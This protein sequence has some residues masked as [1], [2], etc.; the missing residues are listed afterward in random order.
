M[1]RP[2]GSGRAARPPATATRDPRR[3]PLLRPART[4]AFPLGA[5]PGAAESSLRSGPTA[6]PRPPIQTRP[7]DPPTSGLA[8][9]PPGLRGCRGSRQRAARVPAH[10]AAPAPPSRGARE[11]QHRIGLR[12]RVQGALAGHHSTR[13]R[14]TR[15]P[16]AQPT[17]AAPRTPSSAPRRDPATAHRPPRTGAV[18]P[19]PPRTAG[20]APPGQREND[21]VQPRHPGRTLFAE[22]IAAALGAVR[23]GRASSRVPARD[24]AAPWVGRGPPDRPRSARAAPADAGPRTPNRFPTAPLR[25]V[26][27]VG[28]YRSHAGSRP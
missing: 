3:A 15:S 24:L 18:A 9:A 2:Q 7:P 14:R 11:R 17:T 26:T 4:A 6:T 13:A 27:P 10:P 1:R 16:Q 25:C 22:H 23:D 5:P 20:S 19:Q 28:R 8:A 21:P 12:P